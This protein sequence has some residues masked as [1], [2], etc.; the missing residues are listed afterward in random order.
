MNDVEIV[1]K[2]YLKDRLRAHSNVC[3]SH[4]DL[5]GSCIIYILW[6][7]EFVLHDMYIYVYIYVYIYTNIYTNIYTPF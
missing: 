3:V 5:V 2:G 6:A 7:L 1:K 4:T